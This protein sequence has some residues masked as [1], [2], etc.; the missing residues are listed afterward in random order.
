MP[1][2]FNLTTH[3]QSCQTVFLYFFG[4]D[5]VSGSRIVPEAFLRCDFGRR[6]TQEKANALQVSQEQRSLGHSCDASLPLSAPVYN[7]HN[8]EFALCIEKKT[9]RGCFLGDH[10]PLAIRRLDMLLQVRLS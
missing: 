6:G 4:C 9:T 1:H 5:F 8:E 7:M 10:D 2:F 3:I